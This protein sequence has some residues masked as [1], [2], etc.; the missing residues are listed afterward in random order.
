MSFKNFVV[1]IFCQFCLINIVFNQNAP[2]NKDD[3]RKA[4]IMTGKTLDINHILGWAYNDG[5]L[6]YDRS[7]KSAG[8]VYPK[9][10][11]KTAINSSGLWIAGRAGGGTIRMSV[12]QGNQS[13][14]QPGQI[15]GTFDT[16]NNDFSVAA[17]PLNEQFRIYKVVKH[18]SLA[19]QNG[20]Y[21]SWN[22]W[23]VKQGAP[24]VDL[25]GDGIYTPRH[26]DIPEFFGDQMMYWVY[27]DLNYSGHVNTSKGLPMGVEIHVLMW[28][29]NQEGALGNTIFLR[30][31]IINKSDTPYY[32][33]Y[34]SSYID[35][36][37]GYPKDDLPACDTLLNMGYAYNGNS[38]D[39]ASNGYYSQPPALGVDL[40]QGPVIFTGNSFD[41]AK[42]NKTW[43]KGYANL[44]MQSFSY[45]GTQTNIDRVPP[46]GDSQYVSIAYEYM[47]GRRGW[48]DTTHLN[49]FTRTPSNFPL[50]GD[51]VESKG[52]L[53]NNNRIAINP[54]NFKI[55]VSTGPFTFAAKD[56]QEIIYAFIIAQG[57]DKLNSVSLLK[58]Y[59]AV[60]EQAYQSNYKIPGPPQQPKVEYSELANEIVLDWSGNDSTELYQNSSYRFEGYNIYQGETEKGPWKRISTFDVVNGIREIYDWQIDKTTGYKYWSPV[61]FG[62]DTGI[63]RNLRIITDELTGGPLINGKE[64]YFAVTAYSF[65]TD[66]SVVGIKPTMLENF[67]RSIIIVPHQ[68][69][70]G[71]E[72]TTHFGS[73]LETNRVGDDA[74]KPVVFLPTALDGKTYQVTFD[75][76]GLNIDSWN[77]I[78]KSS[79]DTLIKASKDFSGDINSPTF[80]GFQVRVTKPRSGV[81]RDTQ[82]PSGW[83]Y[84]NIKA[85]KV[86]STTSTNL[87]WFKGQGNTTIVMD[88]IDA[89]GLSYPTM[90]NF[91]FRNSAVPSD[92][93]L[94]VEIRFSNINTQKAYR[95]ISNYGFFPP[96]PPFDS[97]FYPY[98]KRNGAGWVYQDYN[99]FPSPLPDTSFENSA[100]GPV[101]PFT[102]WE[103][104]STDGDFTQRQLNVAFVEK[105]DSLWSAPSSSVTRT[106]RGRGRIDGKWD[107]TTAILGGSEYLFILK[108]TYSDT[109]KEFYKNLDFGHYENVDVMYVFWLRKAG[110][111]SVRWNEGDVLKI[112]PNYPLHTRRVYEFVA[113]KPTFDN[114]ML[115]KQQMDRIKV[116]PNPY[117]GYNKAEKSSFERFVTFSNLPGNYQIR[118]FSL[119]GDLIRTIL[120]GSG[121]TNGTNTTSFERWDL[122]NDYGLYVASGIY[123]AH[124]EIPEVSN[125]ILKLVIVQPDQGVSTY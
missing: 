68:P 65:N 112:T 61:A 41:S 76:E 4:S 48:Y 10:T 111:D 118:I 75:G 39:V 25:N 105:N 53:P 1:F 15:N 103:V 5:E 108:S 66:S 94:K 16:K 29:Y 26:G 30:Y 78:E 71:S 80:N 35:P 54:Q 17:N 63:K 11:L 46:I 6:F 104:D 62:N 101:V 81:R 74:V 120:R 83:S 19:A 84:Y 34:I 31:Q 18:D 43:L 20:E 13:E 107:P 98:A 89:T 64:Y 55:L 106:Y 56:T 121:Y 93:I 59:D 12:I 87:T 7:N 95:Y 125:K 86:T 73:V 21:D 45:F 113:K 36:D 124:I 52:W 23:P 96:Y 42:V 8:F 97:S 37:I 38:V 3:F 114:K 50:S 51:P 70:I 90:K 40:L 28:G 92:S 85:D 122:K 47:I 100:L 67:I 123:I 116:F 9:G 91:L 88:A 58:T 109:A 99:R 82:I 22:S 44:K 102:V 27:N 60:V 32:D 79:R 57:K 14:F 24:W 2:L 33:T 72:I 49:P 115:M 117:F 110:L 77:L 119:S 69:P